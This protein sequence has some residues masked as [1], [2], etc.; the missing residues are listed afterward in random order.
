MNHIPVSIVLSPIVT[1]DDRRYRM[2]VSELFCTVVRALGM[3][4]LFPAP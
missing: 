4:H 3:C 2:D 1:E